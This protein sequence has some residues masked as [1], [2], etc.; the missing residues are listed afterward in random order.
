MIYPA[1][2]PENIWSSRR[3]FGTVSARLSVVPQ[4][5]SPQSG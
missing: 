5:R 2:G 3:G 4:A 1:I